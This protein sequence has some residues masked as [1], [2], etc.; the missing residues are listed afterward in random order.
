MRFHLIWVGKTKNEHLRALVAD[1]L[2]RLEHFTR[3]TVTEVREGTRGAN[4]REVLASEERHLLAAL[5]TEV[6]YVLLSE[7]GRMYS[8]PELARQVEDWQGSGIR[9]LAFV[10]GGHYGFS[11]EMRRRAS[12]VWS[13]SRLTYTHEMARVVLVE[14]LY[15]AFT[16]IRGLPYQK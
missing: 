3:C 14:Q 10:I 6:P 8:S 2:Q 7:E 1:Y 4:E 5:K 11:A 16:I 12:Q 9:E 13:L 15:R